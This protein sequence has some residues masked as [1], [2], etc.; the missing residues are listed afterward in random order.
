MLGSSELPDPERQALARS[1]VQM[2]GT[3]AWEPAQQASLVP[4][5][6]SAQGQA[7]ASYLNGAISF[8]SGRFADAAQAFASL[9]ESPQPWLKE[10]AQYMQARTASTWR[11]RTP[12]I[13]TGCR[14]R[15]RPTQ[16]S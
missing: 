8:Y 15:K 11:N 3:C 13:A 10:T 4:A 12:S 14:P 9:S 2:L 1:R 6:Q 16:S 7:F 5:V